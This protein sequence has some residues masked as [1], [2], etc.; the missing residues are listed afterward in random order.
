MT[1]S[2]FI[3][4]YENVAYDYP[5]FS[6]NQLVIT[7]WQSYA[8]SQSLITDLSLNV[9]NPWTL[10]LKID[11]P[12][13]QPN[14]QSISFAI[15]YTNSCLTNP[16]GGGNP[17]ANR[18]DLSTSNLSPTGISVSP[19]T[20]LPSSVFDGNDKYFM[21]KY[22]S[23]SNTLL[24]FYDE[25]YT[26]VWNTT[27][28]SNLNMSASKALFNHYINTGTATIKGMEIQQNNTFTVEQ[29][30]TSLK[31]KNF[32]NISISNL[33]VNKPLVIS[34]TGVLT[35]ASVTNEQ[36]NGISALGGDL[37]LSDHVD[38]Y[39]ARTNGIPYLGLYRT[40]DMVKVRTLAPEPIDMIVNKPASIQ[41]QAT[42][43]N[44]YTIEGFF[45]HTALG[46]APT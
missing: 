41:F 21:I 29:F 5:T 28:T 14:F 2:N 26:S 11:F 8:P 39:D 32:N 4:N 42:L 43:P 25:N 30:D 23:G 12:T 7:G 20:P 1:G 17:D 46:A 9:T 27:I 10:F 44:K 38:D 3:V 24:E 22:I 6:N 13:G 33:S 15:D 16:A 37:S 34:S 45:Y 19:N 35:T 40:G 31:L 18:I 36:L